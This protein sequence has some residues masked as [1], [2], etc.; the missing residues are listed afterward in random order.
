MSDRISWH[1]SK[2]SVVPQRKPNNLSL[3]QRSAAKMAEKET[4]SGVD[5]N[6]ETRVYVWVV[7]RTIMW[8]KQEIFLVKVK[9]GDVCMENSGLYCNITLLLYKIVLASLHSWKKLTNRAHCY[10]QANMSYTVY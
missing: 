1:F 10:K 3:E 8:E 9:E 6:T 2:Q 4:I 7:D 5:R